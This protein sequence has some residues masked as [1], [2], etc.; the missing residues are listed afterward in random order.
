MNQN[1]ERALNQTTGAVIRARRMELKYKYP[2]QTDLAFEAGFSQKTLSEIERDERPLGSLGTEKTL[3][4]ARALEWSVD[5]L[6]RAVGQIPPKSNEATNQPVRKHPHYSNLYEAGLARSSTSVEPVKI[7]SIDNIEN[8]ANSG[9][10]ATVNM[11]DDVALDV[12]AMQ[13][14]TG[15]L[16]V[17]DYGKAEGSIPNQHVYI[18]KKLKMA[19]VTAKS[20]KNDFTKVKQQHGEAI[21]IP[22]TD[23]SWEFVG[24]LVMFAPGG[25]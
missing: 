11:S 23:Q 12:F 15:F 8:V 25:A 17:L 1:R 7:Q 14:P 13:I 18:N 19:C 2:T 4:L 10:L 5:E 3:G 21:T 16:L 24:C 6:F 22:P 9:A 20:L